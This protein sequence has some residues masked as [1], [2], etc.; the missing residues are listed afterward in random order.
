MSYEM[1]QQ[2]RDV[3]GAQEEATKAR[4]QRVAQSSI[5]QALT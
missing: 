1:K 5:E 3:A 4:W 2:L